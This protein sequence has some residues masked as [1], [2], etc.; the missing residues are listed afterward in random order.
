[1][2]DLDSVKNLIWTFLGIVGLYAAFRLV[3][4]PTAVEVFRQ[5][6]FA[7]RRE[8]FL[9]MADGNIEASDPAY[10][11]TRETMNALLRYAERVSVLRSLLLWSA[12]GD[13]LRAYRSYSEA[14]LSR[15]KTDA[16]RERLVTLRKELD[17]AV[18][19]YAIVTS[20]VLAPLFFVLTVVVLAVSIVV[21]L[22][23]R[24]LGLAK[25]HHDA[26]STMSAF[27]TKRVRGIEA[28][29]FVAEGRGSLLAA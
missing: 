22:G 19:A 27:A 20:P 7:L 23:T 28:E 21:A 13:E 17:K 10:R 4:L 15:V 1:M 6:V 8:L 11:H 3:A 12:L 5:R 26:R 16:Q 9:W 25:G 29:A 14:I 24:A 18:G 2:N